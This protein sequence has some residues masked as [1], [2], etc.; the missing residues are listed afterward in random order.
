[1]NQSQRE[2]DTIKKMSILLPIRQ[3]RVQLLCHFD[4]NLEDS[5]IY[6]REPITWGRDSDIAFYSDKA[7]FGYCVAAR[8]NRYNNDGTQY[9][10]PGKTYG[11][12]HDGFVAYDISDVDLSGPFCIDFWTSETGSYGGHTPML[13]VPL[14]YDD[15]PRSASIS[16]ATLMYRST[17]DSACGFY[18]YN[19]STGAQDFVNVGRSS[20]MKHIAVTRDYDN[21]IRWFKDGTLVVS[22]SNNTFDFTARQIQVS[23]TYSDDYDTHI[24]TDELRIVTG[25]PWYTSNFTPPTEP[26]TTLTIPPLN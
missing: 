14:S 23:K 21:T 16:V 9:I 19:P 24:N 7:K 18:T 22:Y 17:N 4:Q 10:P 3:R 26:Y 20:T 6:N 12:R 1:M 8:G 13:L 5:S 25:T 11:V 2:D 15:D